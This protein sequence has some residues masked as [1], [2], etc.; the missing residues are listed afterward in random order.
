MSALIQIV[1]PHEKSQRRAHS[2]SHT[3]LLIYAILL[4]LVQVSL[5]LVARHFPGVL[6]FASNIRVEEVIS[7]TNEERG[8][9]G[10]LPLKI[11][12]NLSQAAKLK[13]LYM[14]DKSFWAHVAPDGTTPWKFIL[15]S[16]YRYLYA[17]ENLAKDFGYSG[18]V[19]G[20]W[21]N[22]KTGHRENILNNN[23]TDIGVAVVNGTLS[24]FETT[25]VVQMFGSTSSFLSSNQAQAAAPPSA[26]A[27]IPTKNVTRPTPAET[28]VAASQAQVLPSAPTLSGPVPIPA[29][30]PARFLPVI[31]VVALAKS[32][33]F[34]FGFFLFGLIILDSFVVLRR[35]TVRIA[36]HNGAHLLV[37][38]LLLSSTWFLNAGAIR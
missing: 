12:E 4:L 38:F 8:K 17:G 32:V 18:D 6:G 21:M 9:N 37:L 35:G 1:I 20:A 34:A 22:S 31:D 27:P 5:N 36:G 29:V 13:A 15:Q 16:G 26:T 19:V 10:L 25:L 30:A 7:Q 11:N 33:S 24:G 14:F 3:A 2:L 28:P 23:Y